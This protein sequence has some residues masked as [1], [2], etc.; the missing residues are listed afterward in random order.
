MHRIAITIALAL[1]LAACAP[2]EKPA[3]ADAFTI[4]TDRLTIRVEGDPSAFEH[5]AAQI[6]MRIDT[7][8][9]SLIKPGIGLW[10][11]PEDTAPHLPGRPKLVLVGRVVAVEPRQGGY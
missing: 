3:R 4:E 6:L 5:H 1:G 11:E 10:A 2:E 7:V 8:E 9:P